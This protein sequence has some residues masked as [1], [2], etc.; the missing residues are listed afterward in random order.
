MR[1]SSW[2]ALAVAVVSVIAIVERVPEVAIEPV[3]DV[4]QPTAA[5]G[6]GSGIERLVP[7]SS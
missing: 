6:T 2:L 3:G 7:S 1:R 5:A 4:D